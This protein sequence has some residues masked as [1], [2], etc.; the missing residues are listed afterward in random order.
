MPAL[1]TDS[2]T[3]LHWVGIAAALLSGVIHLALSV[4]FLPS[5]MGIAFLLAAGGFA[6][7]VVLVLLDYRRRLV[8]LVGIPFTAVQ[9]VGWYVVNEPATLADL[10]VLGVADKLAQ[11]V[12]I[13]VLVVLYRRTA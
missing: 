8:Y 1:E 5:P 9:I 10:S 6:G 3:P 2:L 12:L 13:V 7:A 11:F 4:P